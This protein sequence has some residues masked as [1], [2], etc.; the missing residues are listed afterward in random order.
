MEAKEIVWNTT[1]TAGTNIVGGPYIAGNFWAKPD[2]SGFSQTATDADGDG[3][4][5]TAYKLPGNNYTD[6]LPLVG[7]FEPKQS[8]MPPVDFNTPGTGTSTSETRITAN[9]TA[10]NK[11][12]TSKIEVNKTETNKTETAANRTEIYTTRTEMGNDSGIEKDV[13]ETEDDMELY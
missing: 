1:K 9:E 4:A 13:Y 2:G 11:T 3:I 5:D 7:G 8:V 6:F 12:E 10:V